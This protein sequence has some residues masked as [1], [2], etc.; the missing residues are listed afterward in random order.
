[1]KGLVSAAVVIAIAI[2]LNTSVAAA[3]APLSF[4]WP[5]SIDVEPDGWLLLVENGLG[6]LVRISPTGRV[7]LVATLTKPYAVAE[8][9][10]G[11]IYVTDGSVLLRIDGRRPP[12]RVARVDGDIGPIAVARG[13]DVYFTTA[14]RLWRLRGGR[15]AP[16]PVA[17]GARLSSPHGLAVARDGT[18]LVADTHNHRIVRVDTVKGRVTVFARLAVP[19]GMDIGSDGTVYVTDGSA[20]RVVRFSAGGARLGFAGP[21]F[22]DPYALAVAPG[23]TLYVVESL[24][25]GDVRRIAPDGTVTTVSRRA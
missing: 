12:V 19:G 23:G 7:Q 14:A 11:R 4:V 2:A 17:A 3:P 21:V 24:Q 20:G 6:V 9:H 22:D 5:T 10:S 1:M 25:M 18:V 13:G 8:A 16:I 15:G